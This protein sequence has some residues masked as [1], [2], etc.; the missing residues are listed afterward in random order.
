MTVV[1]SYLLLKV[2]QK[3]SQN[4]QTTQVLSRLRY[5]GSCCK[6]ETEGHFSHWCRRQVGD[7]VYVCLVMDVIKSSRALIVAIGSGW[8]YGKGS[9]YSTTIYLNIQEVQRHNVQIDWS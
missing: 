5:N 4:D 1:Y 6:K 9:R 2:K 8:G 7:G 3:K